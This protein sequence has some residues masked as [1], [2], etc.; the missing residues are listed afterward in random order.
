MQQCREPRVPRNQ[1]RALQATA[2]MGLHS[3]HN[4]LFPPALAAVMV[5]EPQPVPSLCDYT[6]D[7]GRVGD[8]WHQGI[9]FSSIFLILFNLP[10][11][12]FVLHQMRDIH[13]TV[14]AAQCLEPL[15]HPCMGLIATKWGWTNHLDGGS[16]RKVP[17]MPHRRW[18]KDCL[19][20]ESSRLGRPASAQGGF[21]AVR[22]RP[23][24]YVPPPLLP[25]MLGRGADSLS[26]LSRRG[27]G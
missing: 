18:T 26:P 24:Q 2:P 25:R 3:A 11:H 8:S 22:V 27:L 21:P 9:F 20:H 4:K 23:V 12:S 14:P 10:F 5:A 15:H 13:Q 6:S 19:L 7:R 16:H 17:I 1:P